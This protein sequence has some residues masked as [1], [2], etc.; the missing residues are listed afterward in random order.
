MQWFNILVQFFIVMTCICAKLVSAT[1]A[2][3][4]ISS[5]LSLIEYILFFLVLYLKTISLNS[6]KTMK[7]SLI[8]E[9]SS[10]YV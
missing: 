9:Y 6:L 4:L 1:H 10:N 3:H 5:K 7:N 8:T 2:H